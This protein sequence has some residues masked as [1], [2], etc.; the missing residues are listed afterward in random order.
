MTHLNFEPRSSRGGICA[1]DMLIAELSIE[2]LS[3]DQLLIAVNA[4]EQAR[5][6]RGEEPL[7]QERW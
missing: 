1:I 3:Y 4:I 6:E 7:M 2:K 5:K